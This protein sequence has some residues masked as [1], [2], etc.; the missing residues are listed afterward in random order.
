MRITVTLNKFKTKLDDAFVLRFSNSSGSI[1]VFSLKGE[2]LHGIEEMAFFLL[3][4][5]EGLSVF[6]EASF[7]AATLFGGKSGS[8]LKIDAK[9]CTEFVLT[10]DSCVSS[11]VLVVFQERSLENG[12]WHLSSTNCLE[13]IDVKFTPWL[14]HLCFL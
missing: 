10:S 1:D 3:K 11:P 5:G 6:V 9:V 7:D 14:S 12:G 2:V 13:G 8:I 4:E